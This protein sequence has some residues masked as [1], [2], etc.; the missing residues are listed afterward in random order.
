[1]QAARA[2]VLHPGDGAH[3]AR[4]GKRHIRNGNVGRTDDGTIRTFHAKVEVAVQSGHHASIRQHMAEYRMELHGG[5]DAGLRGEPVEANVRSSE[6]RVG[7]RQ[8]RRR[9]RRDQRRR[10][11]GTSPPGEGEHD[12]VEALRMPSGVPSRNPDLP[13]NAP[14][15]RATRQLDGVRMTISKRSR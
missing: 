13:R 10:W 8:H 3:M 6:G 14:A 11:Q 4:P 12:T 7:I 15:R 1:M 9:R 5:V 2:D